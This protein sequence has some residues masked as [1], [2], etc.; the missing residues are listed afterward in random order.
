MAVVGALIPEGSRVRI[1]RGG[2]PLDPAAIGRMG[3]VVESNEYRANRY[4]V[5][6]DGEQEVRFF[7][8]VELEA[9]E[10]Q[11]MMLTADRQAAKSR[12]ALP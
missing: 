1:K 6:L 8:P 12:R 4:G 7:A 9:L 5:L 10:E 3:T 2:L 11:P